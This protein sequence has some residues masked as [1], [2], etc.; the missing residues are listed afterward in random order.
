MFEV[1]N[2]DIIFLKNRAEVKIISKLE[3][4]LLD[5]GSTNSK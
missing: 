2:V 1:I 4:H 3:L 5:G